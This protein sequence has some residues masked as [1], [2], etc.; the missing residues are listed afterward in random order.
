MPKSPSPVVWAKSGATVK[1][2]TDN[3]ARINHC[4]SPIENGA[5]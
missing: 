5:A 3:D 4:D 2:L 1:V